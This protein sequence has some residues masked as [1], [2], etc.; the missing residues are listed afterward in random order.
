MSKRST[1]APR[2]KHAERS[3]LGVPQLFHTENRGFQLISTLGPDIYGSLFSY[4]PDQ[5]L[6]LDEAG[7]I[8]EASPSVYEELGYSHDEL[9]RMHYDDI[10]TSEATDTISKHLAKNPQGTIAFHTEYTCKNGKTKPV[11]VR[12]S[13]LFRGAARILV[14]I[15]RDASNQEAKTKRFEKAYQEM[16]TLERLRGQYLSGIAHDLKT[17]LTALKGFVEILLSGKSGPLTSKQEEFLR[18]C[19]VA[20]GREAE[21]VECLHQ[22]ADARIGRPVLDKG[23]IDVTEVLR[24]SIA[25]LEPLAELNG[26]RMESAID[27]EPMVVNG[28]T[29][30]LARVFNNLLSNAIKY[31]RPGGNVRIE[32]KMHGTKKVC[33]SVRDTG[34]GIPPGEH[35][36]IFGRYYRGKS[37]ASDDVS[38]MG[39][40]LSVVKE[41]VQLHGGEVFVES[42]PGQGSTFYVLL[43]L[44]QTS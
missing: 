6:V 36:K 37:T 11:E 41:I 43:T 3:A 20:I 38:G 34:R 8:L 19:S 15:A 25:L 4:L 12:F 9:L 2:A 17:P 13:E 1:T 14:T 26:I 7:A 35:K 44:T 42:T 18:S 27:D 16:Q 33:I 21:L 31:N 30:A 23:E 28:D 40:G 5:I 39:I 24:L 10:V 32:A 22:Y 29:T